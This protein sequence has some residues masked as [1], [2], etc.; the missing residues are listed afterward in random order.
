MKKEKATLELI[1]WSGF[2]A[3]F[4]KYR[5]RYIIERKVNLKEKNQHEKQNQISPTV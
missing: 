4:K 2:F 1:L 3:Y 5:I